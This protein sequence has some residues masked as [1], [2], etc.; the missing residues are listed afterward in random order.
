MISGASVRLIMDVGDWDNS[1][2]INSPGQSGDPA[3]P[4]FGDMAETWA[5]GEY[6]PMVYETASVDAATARVVRLL[7]A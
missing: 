5:R 3:S 7:P 4:H 6:V 2:W 1:V